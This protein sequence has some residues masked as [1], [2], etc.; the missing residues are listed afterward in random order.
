LVPDKLSLWDKLRGGV[1]IYLDNLGP[2]FQD[3]PL[4]TVVNQWYAESG[5]GPV[6]WNDPGLFWAAKR[7]GSESH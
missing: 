5:F 6:A 2:E 3:R 7:A 4:R 1:F